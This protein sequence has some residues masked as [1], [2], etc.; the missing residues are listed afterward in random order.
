MKKREKTQGSNLTQPGVI[1]QDINPILG[2]T[3]WRYI[4]QALEIFKLEN[5][6]SFLD[7]ETLIFFF[8][9]FFHLFANI[10]SSAVTI[11]KES[12]VSSSADIK[13]IR[14]FLPI[15]G[16]FKLKDVE[17]ILGNISVSTSRA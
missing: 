13:P 6:I 15:Y 12:Q 17:I 16:L 1:Q 10:F 4:E 14:I 3:L 8:T 9:L 11:L 7:F 5:S 2:T